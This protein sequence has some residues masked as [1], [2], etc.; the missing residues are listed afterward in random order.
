MEHTAKKSSK[1][2]Q[3]PERRPSTSD[4]TSSAISAAQ[5][6]NY[7]RLHKQSFVIPE[8]RDL[9]VVRLGSLAVASKAKR[10]VEHGAS[11]AKIVNG[12]SLMQPEEAH[13]GLIRGLEPR[14][15]PEP[16]LSKE[17]FHAPLKTL[18][19]PVQISLGYYIFEVVG[20]TPPRQRTL[21]EA[22]PEAARQ[23]HQLLQER[24]ISRYARDFGRK[25]TT[26][27]ECPPSGLVSYCRRAKSSPTVSREALK[28]P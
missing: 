9:Y 1:R 21:A 27:T 6:A 13:G 7:Y 12:T 23:L 4:S 18:E 3:A 17:V 22:K 14:D 8:R 26:R 2:S 5:A 24:I 20:K 10:E 28:I 19:G 16:P 11:F 25:W 15:W